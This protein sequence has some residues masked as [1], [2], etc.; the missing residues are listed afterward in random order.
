MGTSSL[1]LDWCDYKAAKYAVEHWHYS[2]S[3]PTPP[4]VMVG[5]WEQGKYIGVVIFSRGAN[6]H[7][8]SP[9][10][11]LD[12]ETCELTRVAL[13]EHIC[14][15]SKIVAHALKFLKSNSPG[16]K[17]CVSFADPN[18]GHHGG[19]YQAG[20]WIYVGDT[21]KSCKYRDKQGRIWHQRQVSAVGLKP[22]YGT[23]R[24]C[25]VISE[26]ERIPELGKHRYIMPLDND[27]REKIKHLSKPYPKRLK[28]HDPKPMGSGQCDSDPDAPISNEA[29]NEGDQP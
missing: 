25:A 14:P 4:L 24:R 2:K 7:L 26:C 3:M 6:N 29:F 18:H 8:G 12:I 22:Q 27:T 1:R 17:L 23:M 21:S 28:E 19:I 9:Y 13:S 10:N 16:L 15:T 20:N 11:L 5:A